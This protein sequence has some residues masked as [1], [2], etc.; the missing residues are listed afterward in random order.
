MFNNQI[1]Y[2]GNIRVSTW[3]K[4]PATQGDSE[5]SYTYTVKKRVKKVVKQKDID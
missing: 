2:E 4:I 3:C 1:R 5:G